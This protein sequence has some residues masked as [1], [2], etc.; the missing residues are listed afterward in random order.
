[1]ECFTLKHAV[2]DWAETE[3]RLALKVG[4]TV[5]PVIQ[6]GAQSAAIDCDVRVFDTRPAKMREEAG[7]L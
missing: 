4:P 5:F 6:P 3:Q 7:W 1:M 2:R